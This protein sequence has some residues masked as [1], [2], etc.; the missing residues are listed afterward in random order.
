[1]CILDTHA[2]IWFLTDASHLSETARNRIHDDD[3]VYVSIVS[4]WEIA[5]KQHIGK[6]ELNSTIAGFADG[7]KEADIEILGITPEHLDETKK[8]PDIHNDPFDRLIIAQAKYEGLEIV[9]KDVT[10]PKYQVPTIW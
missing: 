6:L 10:I 9:T 2:A 4:L 1:M 8:L 7:C 3:K 5:I